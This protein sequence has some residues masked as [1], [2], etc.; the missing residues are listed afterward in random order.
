MSMVRTT[1]VEPH[2]AARHTQPLQH[3]ASNKVDALLT[4]ILLQAH[5]TQEFNVTDWIGIWQAWAKKPLP[6]P[7]AAQRRFLETL[8]LEGD[9][10]ELQISEMRQ[11]LF[12]GEFYR[13]TPGMLTDALSRFHSI[14]RPWF[15]IWRAYVS[16]TVRWC[17]AHGYRHALFL[18]RDALPFYVMAAPLAAD[19]GAWRMAPPLS[20]SL[21][22]ASR[23][24]IFSPTFNLHLRRTVPITG[25]VALIDTGCYGSLIPKLIKQL[26]GHRCTG[27]TAVFFFF[28]RNPQIF[29]YMNYIMA[30]EILGEHCDQGALRSL[31][32]FIIYA[33]DIIEALPKPYRI[34]SL[35]ESGD[36][37]THVQDLVSFVLGSSLLAEL[38][39]FA[40]SQSEATHHR[41]EAHGAACNLY[42]AYLSTRADRKRPT[43][44]LFSTTSPKVL[45]SAG[46]YRHLCGLMPQEELFGT[47]AG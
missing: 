19:T 6:P 18:C 40:G 37:R 46:E 24:L 9:L 39:R 3:R 10:S 8:A 41:D 11:R 15:P 34:E 5:D 32:D 43:S 2:N 31:S 17:R 1:A 44:L 35:D 21:L 45:P 27:D 7:D 23:R 14:V 26:E 4:E 20:A 29:G 30:W 28:S 42:Q 36:P 12:S 22:H 38:N 47:I 25:D 33:G 16:W 13:D